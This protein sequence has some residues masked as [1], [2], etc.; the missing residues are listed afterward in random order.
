VLRQCG[1]GGQADQ[2]RDRAP[3][4]PSAGAHA[5]AA[6]VAAATAMTHDR[7][8]RNGSTPWAHV[9]IRGGIDI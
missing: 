9:T 6:T 4:A 1:D 5:W 7:M 8:T 3:D 2:E